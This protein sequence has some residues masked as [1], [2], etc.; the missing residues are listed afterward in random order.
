VTYLGNPVLGPARQRPPRR[1]CEGPGRPWSGGTSFG[2]PQLPD[3]FDQ[4]RNAAPV[5]EWARNPDRRRRALRIPL[6]LD[7]PR[8]TSP[9]RL[10]DSEGPVDALAEAVLRSRDPWAG[11]RTCTELTPPLECGRRI[12]PHLTDDQRSGGD[13]DR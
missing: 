4:P 3:P 7:A 2:N 5:R 8:D 1:S 9:V 12:L 13:Y 6:A 11:W 10:L